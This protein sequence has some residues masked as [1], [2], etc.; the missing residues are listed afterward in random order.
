[1]CGF[2]NG[3]YENGNTHIHTHTY[4]H[5]NQHHHKGFSR[6]HA[7]PANCRGRRQSASVPTVA[8]SFLADLRSGYRYGKTAH[9][10]IPRGWWPWSAR[11]RPRSLLGLWWMLRGCWAADWSRCVNA[12]WGCFGCDVWMFNC[13]VLSFEYFNYLLIK[14][15]WRFRNIE[16]FKRIDYRNL[17][18]EKIVWEGGFW[19][20]VWWKQLYFSREWYL[21]LFVYW[22]CNISCILQ[23]DGILVS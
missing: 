15:F 22:L 7:T 14:R 1:M 12:E 18:L 17:R 21:F 16:C 20:T 23:L 6:C 3:A 9:A 4:T 19:R 10:H 2:A 13:G 11:L 5:W 8:P